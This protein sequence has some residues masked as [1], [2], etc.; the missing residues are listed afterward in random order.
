MTAE[1]SPD[2]GMGPTGGLVQGT[3]RYG[4]EAADM[5]SPGVR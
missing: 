5:G 4:Y 3:T 2:G 1:E